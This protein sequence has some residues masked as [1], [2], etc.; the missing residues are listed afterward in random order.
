MAGVYYF[1]QE[2]RY[3]AANFYE[4]S[5][6]SGDIVTLRDI[7][8]SFPVKGRFHFRFRTVVFESNPPATVWMEVTDLSQPVPT[9]K[10]NIL[11]RAMALPPFTH[12]Q[13]L[14]RQRKVY[15][16]FGP[17]SAF[18]PA[19]EFRSKTPPPVLHPETPHHTKA[20]SV[21]SNISASSGVTQD[22]IDLRSPPK[23]A[24]SM[25]A[26]FPSASVPQVPQVKSDL[27]KADLNK[28]LSTEELKAQKT[29]YVEQKAAIKVAESRTTAERQKALVDGKLK[30]GRELEERY[31]AWE[32]RHTQKN[33]LRTLLTTLHS[34][35]WQG[36]NWKP[37]GPGDLVTTKQVRLQFLK[38]LQV[39]HPDHHQNDPAD[40]QFISERC[41]AA[42]SEAWR[43]FQTESK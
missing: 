41:Y 3:K 31:K 16:V 6:S 14:S 39:V 7:Q 36:S 19:Q 9:F 18:I 35:M 30:V 38:A 2:D 15:K 27:F 34:V 11:V 22:F 24:A 23:S 1:T 21:P 4:F 5:S 28:G 32:E 37:I 17:Q 8:Q 40:I 43:R 20:Q 13:T 29:A 10:G 42:L 12:A 33:N 26:A 25:F